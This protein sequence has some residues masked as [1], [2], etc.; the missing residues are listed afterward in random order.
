MSDPVSVREAL[1]I[2][3][4]GDAAKLI[5]S[6]GQLTSEYRK[7]ARDFDRASAGL[8][9]SLARFDPD[10]KALSEKAKVQ[11]VKHV[12]ARTDEAA[13][14]AI[15]LQR[16]AVTDAARSALD[17]ELG[18]HF[19]RLQSAIRPLVEQSRRR[20]EQWLMHASVAAVVSAAIWALAWTISGRWS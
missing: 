17:A 1:I 16:R 14:Y 6:A 18:G 3:A 15:E 19:Q 8:R 7:A 12:L 9:D 2:E 10:I 20:W 5:E 11:V 4:I 13:R